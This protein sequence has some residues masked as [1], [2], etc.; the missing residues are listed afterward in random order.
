MPCEG[1]ADG[2]NFDAFLA[3]VDSGQVEV[4]VRIQKCDFPLQR[5]LHL[6]QVDLH[7]GQ[8]VLY[9]KAER[10]SSGDFEEADDLVVGGLDDRDD[11]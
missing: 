4:A 10:L 11:V 7:N 6:V 2:G 5:L 3:A 1:V 9:G 8:G